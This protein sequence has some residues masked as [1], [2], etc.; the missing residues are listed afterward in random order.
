MPVGDP[1][2]VTDTHEVLA[3]GWEQDTAEDDTLLRQFLL[4]NADLCAVVGD[5]AGGHTLETPAF[6]ATDLGK[7]A[8]FWNAATLLAPPDDWDDVVGRIERF[9][10]HGAGPALLWSAWPT[11][12]LR[13]RGWTLSGH[14]PLLA[15]PPVSMLPPSNT[16]TPRVHRVTTE[17]EL[18]RWERVAAEA[19]PI[20]SADHVSAGWLA[21]PRLL[22]DPRLSFWT[23]V[24]G[25]EPVAAGAAF[26]ARGIASLSF[27]ATLPAHRHQGL[28]RELAVRRLLT[29]P[30]LWFTGVFSDHSRP[31]AERLGFLPLVRL[32]L[33]ILDRN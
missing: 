10:A 19:Y 1:H 29:E 25:N 2:L 12:D 3:T 17:P 11:P 8:G 26:S 27:G 14:P 31:G 28:W 5:A 9:Y 15:R 16:A 23:A 21:P 30:A 24:T 7:P 22:D 20:D 4:H 6:T 13:D 33:W 32:T 18:E